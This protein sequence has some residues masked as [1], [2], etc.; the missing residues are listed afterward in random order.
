MSGHQ[1]TH[2]CAELS[3]VL[4]QRFT[5]AECIYFAKCVHDDFNFAVFIFSCC[6]YRPC[7]VN[8]TRLHIGK[9]GDI[10]RCISLI[11]HNTEM[12]IISVVSLFV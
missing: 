10:Q 7:A 8:L 5:P 4:Q 11:I 6:R 3:L 2:S 9:P 12:S 1:R